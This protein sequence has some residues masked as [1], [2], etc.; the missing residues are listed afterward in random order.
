MV[1]QPSTV[2]FMVFQV[3]AE[4]CMDFRL[5]KEANRGDPVPAYDKIPHLGPHKFLIILTLVR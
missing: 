4:L 2:Y 5:N 1:H 3:I